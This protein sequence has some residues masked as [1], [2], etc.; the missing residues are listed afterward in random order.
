MTRAERKAH[1]AAVLLGA[2]AELDS[3]IDNGAGWL[4]GDAE[5]ADYEELSEDAR[6]YRIKVLAAL[7]ETIRAKA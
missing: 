5:A 3:Q 7:V 4:F 1:R 6:D 2:A